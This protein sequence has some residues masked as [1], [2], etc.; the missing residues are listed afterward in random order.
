[1]CTLLQKRSLQEHLLIHKPRSFS[2]EL[3]QDRSFAQKN[4]LLYHLAS[5]HSTGSSSFHAC[6]ICSKVFPFPFQLKR[7]SSV[8][9]RKLESHFRKS[10]QQPKAKSS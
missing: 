5:V 4:H 8:H 1:M 9:V 7:H 6:T 2:C 10:E 3:C